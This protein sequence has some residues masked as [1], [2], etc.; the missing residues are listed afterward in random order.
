MVPHHS[1][2]CRFVNEGQ[3]TQREGTGGEYCYQEGTNTIMHDLFL[4]C[5][6]VVTLQ[7][8]TKKLYEMLQESVFLPTEE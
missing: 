8:Q 1:V 6:F 7:K 5:C 4:Q 3:D 2:E